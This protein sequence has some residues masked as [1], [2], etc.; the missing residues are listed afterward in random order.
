MPETTP[1]SDPST[2]AKPVLSYGQKAVGISFNPSGSNE[3]N[4]FKQIMAVAIDDLNDLRTQSTS[5]EVK[6]LCS[7]AITELQ[8][9]Q[10][11]GV[12][13]LTWKD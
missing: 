12:K 7:V 3:V 11:W 1:E 4:A 10:M 6:R 5:G 8:T 2:L 13:A 9:A